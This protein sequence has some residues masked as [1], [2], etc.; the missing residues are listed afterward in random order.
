MKKTFC[1]LLITLSISLTACVTP[2]GESESTQA[3]DGPPL[4]KKDM[5]GEWR[6]DSSAN[7]NGY[8]AILLERAT[9][10]FQ[11]NWARDQRDRGGNRPTEENMGRIKTELSELLDEVFK[12]EL[13]KKNVFTISDT[14][15]EGVLRITPKI[16]DLNIYAPDRMRDHIGY[17]LADSKGSMR[18]E[19]EIHDSISG[20]LLAKMSDHREDPHRGYFEWTTEGTNLQAARN[21]FVRWANKLHK[22]LTD[23]RTPARD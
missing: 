11:E 1:A 5:H 14:P 21:M 19:I 13:P 9:V 8:T 7:W 6:L 16:T 20:V 12:R 23:A 17:S 2:A 15:A 3:T 22:W 10:E 4:V 18:L